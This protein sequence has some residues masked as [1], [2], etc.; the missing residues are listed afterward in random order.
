MKILIKKYYILLFIAMMLPT[1]CQL[2][3]LNDQKANSFVIKASQGEPDF[4]NIEWA[5]NAYY[6]YYDLLRSDTEDGEYTLVDRNIVETSVDDQSIVSGKNYY[7]KV[8]GYNQ[9]GTPMYLSESSLGFAGA[10]EG[11]VPPSGVT[12]RSGALTKC[13]EISWD[14]VLEATEYEIYRSEDNKEFVS[15]ARTPLLHYK[16]TK[17]EGLKTYHYQLMAYRGDIPSPG[18]SIPVLGTIF[19]ADLQLRSEPGAYTDKIMLYW[20]AYDLASQYT[21]YR[22]ENET[23]PIAIAEIMKGSPM[24]YEDRD[25]QG[26]TIYYYTISYRN[27][28]VSAESETIRSYIRVDGVSPPKPDNFVAAQGTDQRDIKLTWDQVSG[29]DSYEIARAVSQTGPWTIIGTTTESFYNDKDVPDLSYT[30]FYTVTGMNSILGVRSD[31]KEGWANKPPVKINA[32]DNLGTKVQLSWDR[33]PN[34]SSYII[35]FA[36]SESG[37]YQNASGS[38]KDGNRVIFDHIYD[39]GSDQE[40]SFYYTVEVVTPTGLSIPSKSIKG[41]IRKLIAPQNLRVIG[42]QTRTKSITLTWDAVPGAREYRIYQATL[43][44]RN[45]NPNTIRPEHF[46]YLGKAQNPA[47]NLSFGSLEKLPLYPIRRHQY[48]VKAVNTENIEYLGTTSETVWRLPVDATDFAKDVDLTIIQAQT[49]IAN[50]GQV[51]SKGKINGRASGY[52]DY[53][54]PLFGTKKNIWANY[55]SYEVIIDRAQ[56]IIVDVANTSAK[57]RGDLDVK[58]LYNGKITYNDLNSKPGGIAIGGGLTLYYN[59]EVV[60]WDHIKVAAE[61][62]GVRLSTSEPAARPPND[63][64][65][66]GSGS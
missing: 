38:I 43:K 9:L 47:F 4:V 33:V 7:Y 50:F 48:I 30:Y 10:V 31:I 32:S 37:P 18:R 3:R 28:I 1:A 13:I 60:S 52:Y 21:V 15:I 16:D 36:T 29:A 59:G 63:Y 14:R 57:L 62:L 41:T 23:E 8:R 5:K 20:D 40:R 27:D 12:T 26:G 45:T 44:H 46:T 11:L 66:E 24:Q 54:S 19:G 55:S 58:G 56:Q 61:M 65:E 17:V 39:I 51:N 6:A 2:S 35:K 22:S 25:V 64:V 34:V 53:A 42:N 49:Q